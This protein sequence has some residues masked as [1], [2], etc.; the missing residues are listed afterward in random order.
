M[1]KVNEKNLSGYGQ[2]VFRDGRGPKRIAKRVKYQLYF[3]VTPLYLITFIDTMWLE[4]VKASD[5]IR[6]TDFSCRVGPVGVMVKTEESNV[7]VKVM[8]R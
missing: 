3:V 8:S 5:P 7:T 4:C 2:T 1:C 6:F